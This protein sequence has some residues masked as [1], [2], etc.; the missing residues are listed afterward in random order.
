MMVQTRKLTKQT[1]YIDLCKETRSGC[2][3]SCVCN[4]LVTKLDDKEMYF[5]LTVETR[6]GLTGPREHQHLSI[7]S[8]VFAIM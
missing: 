8:A 4:D 7:S 6:R 1:I 5:L 2:C 3:V